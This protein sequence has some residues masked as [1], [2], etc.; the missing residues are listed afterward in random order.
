MKKTI[1]F[2]LC[3]F[4][5]S[6][7]F[8]QKVL[9]D[10]QGVFIPCESFNITLPLSELAKM[11]PVDEKAPHPK[12]ES[13][14]RKHR[15]PHTFEKTVADGP[16]Y[17]N[18][19]STI[20][21]K[22]GEVSGSMKAPIMNF[23]G[24]TVTG[25]R[26]MDPSGAVS[27][28]H[29]I[30]AIN[31]TTFR[32]Y[33]KST[34]AILSTALVGSLWTPATPNDGD[35]IIM[36]DKAADRW[37]ISQFGTT[38]NRIYIAIS[39]TNNPLGTYYTYTYTSPAF[40][41]YLK[42]SVWQDG[43]YMTSNQAQKVFTFER[44]AMLAGVP[45]ARSVYQNFS[46]PQ[47]SGFFVPMPGDAGDGT[48]PP[49]GT[50]CPIFSYSDNGWGGGFT[51]AVNIYRVT[52]NWVPATPTSTIASAGV[53]PTAAFD[54][55]YSATWD[56]IAQPGTT[57][58]LD[59]I[60]GIIMYRAQ[61]KSWAGYNTVVL[62]W[63][64]RISA[65]QRSIKWCEL[66]Q[67]Q[68]TGVWSMYQE[69]IYTPDA[70]TRW[71][72]GVAMDNNGA[73][74][75]TY[76]KSDATSIY[77]GLYYAGRRPCDPLGTLPVA[78]S[79]AIAGTGSQTGGV[80]RDGDYSQL[81]LDP[82]G[83]TFWNTSEYMG[84]PTGANAARTRIY[85]FQLPTCGPAA[86]VANFMA[87]NT[88]PCIGATVNFTDIST[89]TPT[90]WAWTF[91]PT[92]VTYV[93]GTTAASQNPQVQFS[94]V[95]PYTATLVATNGIGSDSEIK[96]SYI[97]PISP[98][99]LPL[100][101]NFEGATFPPTG[102]TVQNN[103][104]PSIVWGTA[105][106]KG[107]ERRAAAGNTG[108]ATGSAGIELWNYNTD[109][110]QVDNLISRAI[111][112]V[113]ATAPQMTF[114]R[115][116]KYY[117]D[118]ANPNNWHDQLRVF[119]STDCGVTY[120]AAVY[121][122]K[123]VQ[124]AT[125]GTLNTTFTPAVAA[126]WDI[127]TVSLTSY[128]GQNI[129]VKFEISNK[130][131]NNLYLDDININNAAAAVASVIIAQ[132]T[133]TNPMCAGASATFTAT[134]T[135]GGTAPTY[136]WYINGV[137][138]GG[139]TSPT[140]TTTTLTNGQIVSCVMTSNLPGVTGSPATSNAITMTVNPIPA[141]PTAGS[142]SPDCVGQTISLTSNTVAGATYS[143]TGPAA[144]TSSMEDPT[145]P[146][147]TTAMSGTYSVTVTVAGCT[148]LAGT[149]TVVVNPNPVATAEP[150]L[151]YCPGAAVPAN[152]FGSTPAGATFVWTNSNTAIGLAA[153]GT[154][155]L[156]AFTA[157][158]ATSSPI[159]ATITV[160]PTLSGCVGTPITFTITINPSPVTVLEPNQAY[161]AG[162]TVP[163][164]TFV[165][166]PAG[167]TYS[168]TNSNVSIGLAGSGTTS[169]PSFTA[170]N[171]TG[172]PIAGII[173]ITPTLAGCVG[174]TSTYTITVNP[175]PA[176][177][178][179]QSP[180]QCLAGN[181]FTFT[182]TGSSGGGYTYS[183]NFG[184][185]GATPATSTTNNQ[186]GVVYS[187][188]GTYTVTHIV[189]GPGACSST[190]TS[191]VTIY[192]PPTV[193]V[194]SPTICPGQT[195]ALTA[196]G[197]STYSW[198]AGATSTGVNTA[199]AS[200]AT[201]TSYTVTGT[202]GNGCTAT[203]VSTVT[204]SSSLAITVNSPTI[205]AGDTASL[206]A[207]GGSTYSWSA[208]ATST[209]V[210]TAEASPS[211]T[212]SYTVT[213]TTGACSG[214]S[215]STVTVTSLPATPSIS[216]VGLVLTSSSATGNQWYLNGVAIPGATSQNYTVTSN[217]T[218]TVVVTASGCESATSAPVVII[219]VGIEDTTNPFGL[220]IYPNPNDGNFNVAFNSK[221]VSDYTLEIHNALG[222]IVYSEKINKFSGKY[223][224]K[225]SVVEFGQGV[226]TITLTNSNNETV[227]KIIVY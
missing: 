9:D 38:G 204:V 141:T 134:P 139:A 219:N 13:K 167:A 117:N 207:S 48:L 81:V 101:E 199:N 209:G 131:G 180:N 105:G 152:T 86:P 12:G 102:W 31:S 35:P 153:S 160:T 79:V 144:F 196:G 52:V 202:D 17:G 37:F 88:A 15:K 14:D 59:G 192:G 100:V 5:F 188:A 147:A 27:N 107:L 174:A 223:A 56:D 20:Q 77:P 171:A 53:V 124:L 68:S 145:R 172:S 157:T 87:D 46:P 217:G 215:V 195:A 80:N 163:A 170:T 106:A 194:N 43:Y 2:I 190:I 4:L 161:C 21:N 61:W 205:C 70:A 66:R 149:T 200:P 113:G 83:V 225:L 26:P 74:A 116:Y 47:G 189:T 183:W 185:G 184:G 40:P 179:T 126:D 90:S 148:S 94:T 220:S 25:F 128:I 150:N 212:T 103:D 96:T 177:T 182:N 45:T 227:K 54:G 120:G 85:S 93:G 218:Y 186:S 206:T 111:S 158:N 129:I 1:L 132:T 133:G 84:G 99:A 166:T 29:Y 49:A 32:V 135:N 28:T 50:P 142:S 203:A 216:Q 55:S 127:D 112:L 67:N 16:E 201:T 198:S 65:T 156:P 140:F 51:D 222:Q 159:V 173:T 57:Q 33:N 178:F 197:A 168:W 208:G 162:A 41:D 89:N 176:A 23:A 108:S 3:V 36:F 146:S 63:A 76:M 115:A 10:S 191:T 82:D 69:G 73:M 136:Q 98:G 214:T 58:R 42:F 11:Y 169:I 110:A 221:E 137:A 226:Y 24:Q 123:G 78:E 143:W 6:N 72:G 19:P 18:D 39:T 8:A 44:T 224:K 125:S 165:S 130:Y 122:K 30:Q 7:S 181:S 213:G 71:M 97:V 95:G 22:M 210:S 92:S 175:T 164:N 154:T 34:G 109:T 151:T 75:L 193:T 121:Y 211:A 187:T 64:V 119:I 155:S 104:A 118:A 114:K 60:G 62:N 91:S 138:V